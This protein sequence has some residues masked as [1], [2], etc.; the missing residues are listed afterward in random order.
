MET[1]TFQQ[2]DEA[3][4]NGVLGNV[5]N[6]A[7]SSDLK[8]KSYNW[9]QSN[10]SVVNKDPST[11]TII[12]KSNDECEH[13][14][15]ILPYTTNNDTEHIKYAL[16]VRKITYNGV[17]ITLTSLRRHDFE[18]FDDDTIDWSKSKTDAK[19][20]CWDKIK[21]L[22]THD[23]ICFFE[24]F[25]HYDK[26]LIRAFAS[27][28][29]CAWLLTNKLSTDKAFKIKN[30]DKMVS[31]GLNKEQLNT[32]I[33]TIAQLQPLPSYFNEVFDKV[34]QGSLSLFDDFKLQ[35]IV[36]E[37][38]ISSVVS[39]VNVSRKL[40]DKDERFLCQF[41]LKYSMDMSSRQLTL[42]EQSSSFVNSSTGVFEITPQYKITFNAPAYSSIYLSEPEK[43]QDRLQKIF[44]M[45]KQ[46]VTM[47]NLCKEFLNNECVAQIAEN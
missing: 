20:N 12:L 47:R 18:D 43:V 4:M 29:Q 1:I 11:G 14:C 32:Q 19:G 6:F 5:A 30:Y 16:L 36:S 46:I 25:H 44:V 8:S 10:F 2:L 45:F 3:R 37:A 34:F 23:K 41:R 15:Q 31:N 7:T 38:E 40:C 24:S 33:K 39:T 28:I 9:H 21:Y 17:E 22:R 27:M 35:T 13:F 26:M 42:D